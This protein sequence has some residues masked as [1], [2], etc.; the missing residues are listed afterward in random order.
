M[1]LAATPSDLTTI[2]GAYTMKSGETLYKVAL[3]HGGYHRTQTASEV[4]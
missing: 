2:P 3:P 1:A 4:C